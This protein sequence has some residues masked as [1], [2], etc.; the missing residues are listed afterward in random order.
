MDRFVI[1]VRNFGSD[2]EIIKEKYVL[3]E[4]MEGEK[5]TFSHNK[6]NLKH[7][8]VCLLISVAV[9]WT[10]NYEHI[11]WLSNTL[12]CL[13]QSQ[14]MD[15]DVYFKL[16]NVFCLGFEIM[17]HFRKPLYGPPFSGDYIFYDFISNRTSSEKDYLK[18]EPTMV[19][20]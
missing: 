14:D 6:P 19:I 13:M 9:W 2:R 15:R 10:W 18:M 20:L 1:A 8:P 17:L 5:G 12:M 7:L 11:L 3:Q 16:Q 4:H